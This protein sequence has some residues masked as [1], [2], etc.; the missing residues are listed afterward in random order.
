MS[1]VVINPEE[2]MSR[3]ERRVA[4]DKKAIVE[5]FMAYRAALNDSGIVVSNTRIIQRVAKE[6]GKSVST[7][8]NELISAQAI[9]ER[10]RA[11]RPCNDKT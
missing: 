2:W 1:E 9:Y 10:E 11:G 6:L 3:S 5:L 4:A 8:R 7:V